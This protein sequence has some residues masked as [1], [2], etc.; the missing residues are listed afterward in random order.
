M[1]GAGYKL[2]IRCTANISALFVQKIVSGLVQKPRKRNNCQQSE[3]KGVAF[4]RKFGLEND[5]NDPVATKPPG[6]I[7]LPSAIVNM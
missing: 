4:F 3:C 6:M 2:S 1:H 7:R 5:Q